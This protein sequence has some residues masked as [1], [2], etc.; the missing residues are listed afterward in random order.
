MQEV[1]KAVMA[2]SSSFA[3]LDGEL[4][5]STPLLLIFNLE[6]KKLR[7]YWQSVGICH[8][9]CLLRQ[10][11]CGRFSVVVSDSSPN[12]KERGKVLVLLVLNTL[13]FFFFFNSQSKIEKPQRVNKIK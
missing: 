6:L 9:D 1:S 13:L 10:L 12:S 5:L 2:P 11:L 3:R 4:E 8:L 7:E